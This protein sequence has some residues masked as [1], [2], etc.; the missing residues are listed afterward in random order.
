MCL[1]YDQYFYIHRM[2]KRLLFYWSVLCMQGSSLCK[3]CPLIISFPHSCGDYKR[4]SLVVKALLRAHW[5]CRHAH[6]VAAVWLN[7]KPRGCEG[8]IAPHLW[9]VLSSLHALLF[10]CCPCRK[11]SYSC[12]PSVCPPPPLNTR[13][14]SAHTRCLHANTKTSMDVCI[15]IHSPK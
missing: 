12:Q 4:H 5:V 8:Y 14:Q 1:K 11:S 9:P 6:C 10:V 15:P 3:V 7:E 2:L 13:R